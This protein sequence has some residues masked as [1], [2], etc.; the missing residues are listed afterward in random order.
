MKIA[1]IAAIFTLGFGSGM[2]ATA[3]ARQTTSL[4][5]ERVSGIGGVFFKARDPKSLAAWYRQALGIDIVAGAQFAKIPW[6]ERAE[7]S[8]AGATARSLFSSDTKNFAP[9]GAPFMI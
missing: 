1:A 2:W 3:H 9:R 4:P 8:R 5:A 7:S 6:R